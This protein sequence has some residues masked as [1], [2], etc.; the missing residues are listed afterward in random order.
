MENNN[1][2]VNY[3]ALLDTLFE[4]WMETLDEEQKKL[5]CKDG[6]IIIP[7]KKE[8]PE[9]VN[10]KWEHSPRRVMFI[11][12]DKNTPDGDDIRRWLIDEK[13]GENNRNLSGGKDGQTSFLPNIA[14]ML[15]GLLTTGKGNRPNFDSV[16]KNNMDEVRKFWNSK[17]FVLIEAKKLAGFSTVSKK[18]IEYAIN[19]DEIFLK[20]EIDILKP[21][22]IVCCDADDTQ[23]RF[24]T[25]K[26]M[27]GKKHLEFGDKNYPDSKRPGCLWYY[28]EDQIA[29][30]KSYHPTSRGKGKENWKV[31]ERVISPFGG[32]MNYSNP[33]EF[34]IE[35]EKVT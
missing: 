32:L 21:N 17:P 6:L 9:Y 2:F 14:K 20:K 13:N 33:S 12:K 26:Y 4:N 22:I 5:F 3:N 25:E 23:F 7:D 8:N 27:N 16:T 34:Q 28:P 35:K 24:I 11:L 1:S 29:V 15:Y 19:R 30:I 10:E 31:F 18:E